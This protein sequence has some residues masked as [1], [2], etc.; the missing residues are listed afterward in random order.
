MIIHLFVPAN[1][2]ANTRRGSVRHFFKN[3]LPVVVR[4]DLSIDES[5]V[6]ELKFGRKKIFFT[7]LYRNPSFDRASPKFQVFL[8]NF[9]NLHSKI[10][11]KNY[12]AIFFTGDINAHN[13]SFGGL[14]VIPTAEGGEIEELFTSLGLHI[15]SLIEAP[16]VFILS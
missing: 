16:H 2:P 13:G 8:L 14:A 3:S 7:I 15:L 9:E 6:I 10:K 11:A 12:F 1:H 4:N 5:I